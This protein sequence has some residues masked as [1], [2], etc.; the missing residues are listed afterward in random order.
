MNENR[1]KFRV[2]LKKKNR[3]AK[4]TEYN[5]LFWISMDGRLFIDDGYDRPQFINYPDDKYKEGPNNIEDFIVEQCT[6]MRDA[7][8]KLIYEGDIVAGN[9]TAAA[10]VQRDDSGFFIESYF[11]ETRYNALRYGIKNGAVIIGNIN[12]NPE[13][14]KE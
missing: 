4:E 14:L 13:R 3:Y 10:K 6:G 5:E 1:F 7:N 11:P 9:F 8:N 2:F 12:E